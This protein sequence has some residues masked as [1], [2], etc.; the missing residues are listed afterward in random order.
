M[1]PIRVGLDVTPV[2]SG[3]TGVARY[4]EMLHAHAGGFDD[5]ETAP[6]A[7][8]RGPDPTFPVRRVR[9][10]LRVIHRTWRVGWPR[11][12]TLVGPVDVVHTVD[13]VPPPTSR[14]LVMNVMDVLPLVIPEY[15]A[16]RFIRIAEGHASG[17]RRAVLLVTIAA[18]TADQIAEVTGYPRDRI[19]VAPPGWR[20][21]TG[22]RPTSPEPQPYILAVGSVTP[23]KGFQDLA[24]AAARLGSACPPVLVAGP[25]GWR[26]DEV[27]RRV[28]DLGLEQR[29]RFLG[30]VDDATLEALFR[31]AALVCHPSVAEGFG[32]PCLEA[33]GYGVPVVAGD[34]PTVREM[35]DGVIELVPPGDGAALAEGIERVLG[36]DALRGA[37]IDAGRLRAQEYSWAATADKV[38]DAW[39]TAAG[40]G[41]PP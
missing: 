3:N 4:A 35:G 24:D 23:R 17:F 16:E 5:I 2:V 21:S 14:P 12:E 41:S 8:G 19:R 27:R 32:I 36:D 15:Y 40:V 13:G 7:I 26:A 22:P 38:A 6:F 25:D 31:N 11:A 37:M 34:I 10:P 33:M 39:R 18:A 20:P 28:V 1:A 29:V 30:R 9:V